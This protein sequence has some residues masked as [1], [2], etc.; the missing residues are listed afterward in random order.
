MTFRY[1]STPPSYRLVPCFGY[2]SL[3]PIL[4]KLIDPGSDE[5]GRQ[6]DLL[7][8]PNLLW[9]PFGLR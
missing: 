4:M 7:V 3:F 5:L 9:T 1:H 8:D 2:V 6:L